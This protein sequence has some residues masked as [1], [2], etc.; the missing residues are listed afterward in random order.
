M[1]ITSVNDA[2][3]SFRQVLRV[4]VCVSRVNDAQIHWLAV[5]YCWSY[6]SWPVGL[7]Y[8]GQAGRVLSVVVSF[9][10]GLV[11]PAHSSLLSALLCDA[12]SSPRQCSPLVWRFVHRFRGGFCET[13]S[14]QQGDT[15][16]VGRLS[17]YLPG[18]DR[19]GLDRELPPLTGCSCLDSRDS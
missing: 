2:L 5:T 9:L 19:A 8:K 6:G 16:R 14:L 15:S 7:S 1:P 12:H 3:C 11:A 10:F 17:A 13:G 18:A 4:E